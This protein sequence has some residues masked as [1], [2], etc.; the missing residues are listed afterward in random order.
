MFKIA[1]DLLYITTDLRL[2]F[3]LVFCLYKKMYN[4]FDM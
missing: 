2:R 4:Y 1:L 3:L